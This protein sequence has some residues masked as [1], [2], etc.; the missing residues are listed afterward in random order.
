MIFPEIESEM[1]DHDFA[2]FT[3]LVYKHTHIKLGEQKRALMRTRF[4]KVMREL[5]LTTYRAYYEYIVEDTTGKAVSDLMNAISTNLT[6]FF[7]EKK[8]FD[9]LSTTYLPGLI[10]RCNRERR[11]RVRAWSAGSSSGEEAYSI[12]ITLLES[13]THRMSW[14]LKILA[15]DIDSNML[16]RGKEGIY[17]EKQFK[18]MPPLLRQKY[19]TQEGNRSDRHFVVSPELK[20]LVSFRRLNLMEQPW[21]F[22]GSFDFIFCRNVMIY[23]D[24]PTQETLVNRYYDALVPG[25]I[26]FIGH[27]ESLNTLTHSFQ[28]IQPTIY[29][30]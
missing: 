24:R 15:T 8:H 30:K 11:T 20:S 4:G 27:S 1:S 9:F 2:L 22:R 6:H 7:R 18:D 19:F 13:F 16:T 17:P 14:D 28:Y 3:A 21:P 29:Q 26:L 25:G 10:E 23:F 12:A 5:G